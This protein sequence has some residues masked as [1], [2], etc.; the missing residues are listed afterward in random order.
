MKILIAY[1][2]VIP[3]ERYGGTQ[4]VIWFL[5]KELVK[6]GH[7]VTYLV[8]KGSTSDFAKVIPIDENLP[9]H[10]QIPADIDVVHFHYFPKDIHLVKQPYLMTVHGNLKDKKEFIENS[11]FVSKNHAERYGATA[12][13][14]NGL[15]WETYT[16]PDFNIKR[17]YYHFLGKA[18]WRIKNVK[19]AIDIVKRIPKAKLSV[20]G[21]VRFN[22]NMGI[23][24]TFSPKIRFYGMVGGN[25]KDALI[26]ASKGLIFPVRWH[27]PFGLAIIESLYYGC[28]VFGTPYGSLAELITPEV[29]FCSTSKGELIEAVK[30]SHQY[31]AKVCHQYA[32]ENFNSKK[33]TL[34]YV[35]KY[36]QVLD[37]EKLNT[38]QP[39]YIDTNEP[40]FLPWNE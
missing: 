35:E 29:G 15:D 32:V 11:V 14:Y 36:Q 5:G 37:G 7:E 13:V 9:V 23:R 40:K 6:L 10:Q 8:E 4:R 27:E 39:K 1:D 22:F 20:L 16:A 26:N 2:S 24:L 25:E 30:N 34:A 3:V 21:G 31:D 12:F 38:Q 17:K 28:P 18:A 33:M 19:G